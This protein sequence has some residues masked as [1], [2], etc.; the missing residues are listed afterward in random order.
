[1]TAKETIRILFEDTENA[2][3]VFFSLRTSFS[4]ARRATG[5]KPLEGQ[6]GIDLRCALKGSTGFIVIEAKD[7]FQSLI[8]KLLSLPI[9]CRNGMMHFAQLRQQ[10][11]LALLVCGRWDIGGKER[12]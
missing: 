7:K 3:V 11:G 9:F 8:E 10:R 1:M 12:D 6:L 2:L 4:R 5:K